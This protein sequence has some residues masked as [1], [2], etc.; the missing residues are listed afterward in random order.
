MKL[1]LSSCASVSRLL[2]DARNFA[3]EWPLSIPWPMLADGKD[4]GRAIVAHARISSICVGAPSSTIYMFSLVP[5][6][7]LLNFRRLHDFSTAALLLLWQIQ[8]DWLS[9]PLGGISFVTLG[10]RAMACL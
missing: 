3:N 6:P 10:S 8:I 9:K 7:S 2:K 4:D 5:S 1:C